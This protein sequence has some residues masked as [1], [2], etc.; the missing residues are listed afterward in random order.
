[1]ECDYSDYANEWRDSY[2]YCY[3]IPL[4]PRSPFKNIL[5]NGQRLLRLQSLHSFNAA[6][7]PLAFDLFYSQPITIPLS[8]NTAIGGQRLIE[9]S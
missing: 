5:G 4:Y 9:V 6:G 1:M 3:C 7:S 8:H 2:G